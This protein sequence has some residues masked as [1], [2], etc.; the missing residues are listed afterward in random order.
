ML[1]KLI[2][3]CHHCPNRERVSSSSCVCAVDRRDII[4]HA[5]EMY[6]PEGRYKLGTGDVVAMILSRTGIAA[7]WKWVLGGKCDGC[8]KTQQRL[9]KTT[10]RG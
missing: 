4:E 1:S 5:Q 3:I 7:A 10:A 9:N 8:K 6:C 2:L